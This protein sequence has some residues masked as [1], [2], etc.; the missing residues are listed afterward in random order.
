MFAYDATISSL[1]NYNNMQGATEFYL[2]YKGFYGDAN[3]DLR[4]S[5]CPDF[6]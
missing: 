6:R 3:G 5:L 4:Q 1:G 2:Q